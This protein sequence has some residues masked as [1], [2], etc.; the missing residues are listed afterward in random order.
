V[1]ENGQRPAEDE[2][3]SF[4]P[5][6]YLPPANSSMDAPPPDEEEDRVRIPMPDETAQIS[7]LGEHD[8]ATEDRADEEYVPEVTSAALAPSL[9]FAAQRV[10]DSSATMPI[11]YEPPTSTAAVLPPAKT[12]QV[13]CPE[14][15][16]VSMVTLTRRESV[17]FCESCDYPLFWT[18]NKIMLDASGL[19]DDSLRR[20]PGTVGR[21]SITSFPCP[22]C[23][24]PNQVTA[25]D[26]VRC[27]LPLQPVHFEPAPQ[28]VYLPTYAEPEPEP[29]GVPWWVYVLVATVIMATVVLVLALNGNFDT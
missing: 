29:E 22:H 27:G 16:R 26:C 8:L 11:V 17:D 24:E 21:V 15:G 28:P 1:T 20:L 2:D 25:A 4:L 18:P 13:T 14:C 23:A 3:A 7:R 5:S 9:H 12:E 10:P 6:F 19:Y